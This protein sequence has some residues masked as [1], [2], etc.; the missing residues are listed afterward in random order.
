MIMSAAAVST[1]GFC[2]VFF[3]YTLSALFALR[4]NHRP[5]ELLFVGAFL[6]HTL[7]QIA[8]G[9]YLGFFFANPI[10]NEISFLPWCLAGVGLGLRL[11]SG[12][13]HI[14]LYNLWPVL[15]FSLLN[16]FWPAGILPPFAKNQT[17]FSPLF[18]GF[19]VTAH[20]CFVMGA[21]FA[22]LY[23]RRKIESKAFHTLLIWGFVFY[24]VSQVVGATW[25]YL[26]WGSPFHWSDRHLGSAALWCYYAAYLHLS[27]VAKWELRQRA[28]V[29]AFGVVFV[30]AF[31]VD[32][33]I[34]ELASL[35]RK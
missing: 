2:I 6:I 12:D 33:Q 11:M 9:W 10:V 3:G 30:V 29:A 34:H 1:F 4:K 16:L 21:W 32:Y 7:S 28:L 8:R 25:A 19:E 23:L 13:I 15:I 20:A 14:F 27:F 22:F 5:S 35:I 24:S 26:G 17:I 18:F 31:N